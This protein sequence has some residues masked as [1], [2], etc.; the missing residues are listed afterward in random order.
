[1]NC[2]FYLDLKDE[3]FNSRI[4]YKDNIIYST[5][6]TQIRN[7]CRVFPYAHRQINT[8]T[9]L[10]THQSLL[11]TRFILSF[12]LLIT[13]YVGTHSLF[14]LSVVLHWLRHEKSGKRFYHTHLGVWVLVCR[15][16]EVTWLMRFPTFLV[17]VRH[18]RKKSTTKRIERKIQMLK[19]NFASEMSLSF[20]STY[21]WFLYL[22]SFLVAWV[23][24]AWLPVV[25]E[26]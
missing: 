11:V 10:C 1:M 6:T 4:H 9:W 13:C 16:V 17:A 25:C 20:I 15:G 26:N 7:Y 19:N 22:V 8:F 24:L 3:N 12:N 18:W 2:Y 21:H 5:T 23:G 14:F